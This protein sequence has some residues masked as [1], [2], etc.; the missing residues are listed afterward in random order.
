M[1]TDDAALHDLAL[2]N[3]RQVSVDATNDLA[4]TDAVQTVEQSVAIHAG[5]ALRPLIGE[6][7][8][9]DMLQ[10]AE[11]RVRDALASDPQ[12][13]GVQTVSIDSIDRTANAVSVTVRCTYDREFTIEVIL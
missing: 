3:D 4:Q 5:D 2:D 8:T 11:L 12:V 7:V 1:I 6:P 13:D 9:G 10:Y